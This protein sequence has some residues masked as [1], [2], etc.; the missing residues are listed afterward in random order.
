MR[1]RL[2]LM[3]S[4]TLLA[5]RLRFIGNALSLSFAVRTL[6]VERKTGVI[7]NSAGDPEAAGD[8]IADAAANGSCADPANPGNGQMWV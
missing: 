7:L 5:V 3:R 2:K 4:T 6:K 8:L 1:P